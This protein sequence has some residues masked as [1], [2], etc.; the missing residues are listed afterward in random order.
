MISLA[1]L[2]LTVAAPSSPL[3]ASS[4]PPPEPAPRGLRVGLSVGRYTPNVDAELSGATPYEDVFG[5][6]GW[7]VRPKVAWVIPEPYGELSLGLSVGWF[8]DGANA[9]VE[10]SDARSGGET[11]IRLI[12]VTGTVGLRTDW[13]AERLELPVEPY[14]E[15]GLSYTFWR[16][17]RGDGSVARW[18]DARG[19]GGSPGV[20][21]V[22]GVALA[23]EAFDEVSRRSLRNN[24]GVH[25]TDLFFEWR[26]DR[27]LD[28]GSRLRVGD[29]TWQA[30]LQI[31]F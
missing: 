3:V 7:M 5:G 1:A 12:P 20:V 31:S 23:L 11:G 21:G 18:G 25:G 2:A 29:S 4:R 16:I 30:G 15:L 22:L 9:F 26:Y 14:L 10:G 6:G 28:A 8:S 13:L 27:T 19:E 24:F 17:R